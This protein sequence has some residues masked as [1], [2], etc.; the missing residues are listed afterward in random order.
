MPPKAKRA[1]NATGDAVNGK[2]DK[3][4][5][6]SAAPSKPAPVVTGQE[7]LEAKPTAGAGKPDQ[8]AYHAEQDKIKAEIDALQGKLVW[9]LSLHA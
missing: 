6:P 8:A 5:P 2:G 7:E 1:P 3:P 4:A 9:H